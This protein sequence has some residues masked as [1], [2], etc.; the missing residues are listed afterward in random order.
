MADNAQ[1]TENSAS[2]GEVTT[3]GVNKRCG[4]PFNAQPV[5][6][7][8]PMP[9]IVILVHGVNDIGEAYGNQDTG[10]CAGLNE[11]LNRKDLSPH[12]WKD[13][14]AQDIRNAKPS[15]VEDGQC[16][17]IVGKSPI[18]P[19]YWG[20]RP[21]DKEEYLKDDRR[22]YNELFQ[23]YQGSEQCRLDQMEGDVSSGSV[24]PPD[25]SEVDLPYDAYVREESLNDGACNYSYTD[26]FFN[27]L[28][29]NKIKNGGLFANATTNIP[30]MYGPG[31]GGIALYL[32]KWYSRNSLANGG[33][34]SH[35]I[36]DNSHRIYQVFA[37]Q[38]LADLIIAIRTRPETAN[39]A[40]NIIAHS[41]G[42][43]VSMLAN[44]I[45]KKENIR[46]ADC[47]IL[48]HSPYAL[49]PTMMEN[50]QPGFQ[51]TEQARVDTLVSFCQMMRDSRQTYDYTAEVLIK[52]GVL[53]Q[54]L[55]GAAHKWDRP[56]YSR[57]NFGKVYN[58]F[59]P[60]DQ[61]VSL[62]PVQGM[63]WQ[64]VPD[65]VMNRLGDNFKQ[66]VFYQGHPVGNGEYVF[67][68]PYYDV[69]ANIAIGAYSHKRK[70]RATTA[71]A[72]ENAEFGDRRVKVTG[73]ILPEQFD[74]EL[75]VRKAKLGQSD[76]GLTMSA[77]AR[78]DIKLVE[79]MIKPDYL[80]TKAYRVGDILSKKDIRMLN[81][82]MFG[83]GNVISS[84]RV[85]EY[86][87]LIVTRI[88]TAEEIKAQ[89]ENT[90]VSISQ[91]SSIMLN[92]DVPQKAFTYDLAIGDCNA[93]TLNGGRFWLDLLRMADWR[94]PDNP[95]PKVTTY[96][97]TGI[98]PKK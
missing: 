97:Q 17:D 43:I 24:C 81:G 41:Q 8:M 38:R 32:A 33:D 22:Y 18:I 98:L 70:V 19:F 84:V 48:N 47:V 89:A 5:P 45:V 74:F 85:G 26:Q 37:A 10:I 71:T 72:F 80:S 25:Y 3:V 36:Y 91:H 86:N 4:E 57:N 9:C 83:G 49:E 27:Y 6:L 1:T 21:V 35:P 13:F 77:I 56:E 29:S 50:W 87:Q 40:I 23:I 76:M 42:T 73:E 62:K 28:D 88:K 55:E 15:M 16:V 92:K 63:G 44:F 64:G 96:Y 11:R 90:T 69:D 12:V 54:C 67:S 61:T 52:S 66:R 2:N 95:L 46:P 39:D 68:L 14:I 75:M 93:Y 82:R 79:T 58:Y 34:Y 20:Y 60:N 78:D 65:D 53:G 31:S 59:C 30:D 51:Q 94:H 7:S